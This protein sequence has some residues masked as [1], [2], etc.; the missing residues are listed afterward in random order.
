MADLT[1][2]FVQEITKLVASHV[3]TS[4]V[5]GVPVALVPEG[6]L[7]QP[8]DFEKLLP[9]PSR[10]KATIAVRDV[11]S[12][13]AYVNRHMEP[14]TIAFA[15]AA[16]T[17]RCVIDHHE[18]YSDGDFPGDAGWGEHVVQLTREQT[19][20]WKEWTL[21][22]GAWMSQEEFAEFLEERITEIIAPAGALLF[23]LATFF[24]A[25]KTIGFS[26]ARRLDNGQVQL[27]WAETLEGKG[28]SGDIEVPTEFALQLRPYKDSWPE[29][30]G[31]QFVTRARLRWRLHQQ[32]VMFAFVLGEEVELFLDGVHAAAIEHVREETGVTVLLG[33]IAK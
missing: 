1:A 16:G 13:I 22:N 32:A 28:R 14:R 25:S 26:S 2:E 4:A 8:L 15:D 10:K 20:A 21:H 11:E 7:V 12:F 19:T 27:A 17:I 3:T 30:D 23:E 9:K 33:G 6:W 18:A 31:G 29:G 5:A 24:Q